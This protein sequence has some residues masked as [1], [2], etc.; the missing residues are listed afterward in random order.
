VGSASGGGKS[1]QFAPLDRLAMAAAAESCVGSVPYEDYGSGGTNFNKSGSSGPKALKQMKLPFARG[2]QPLEGCK[3]S[4]QASRR[5]IGDGDDGGSGASDGHLGQN[6]RQGSS[7]RSKRSNTKSAS[8]IRSC[9]NRHNSKYQKQRLAKQV[10]VLAPEPKTFPAAREPSQPSQKRGLNES[11][12]NQADLLIPTPA[13]DTVCRICSLSS[14]AVWCCVNCGSRACC[15]C[16]EC[17]CMEEATN[18]AFEY[19]S[20]PSLPSSVPVGHGSDF[21]CQLCNIK[22]ALA[23]AKLFKFKPTGPCNN[24]REDSKSIVLCVTCGKRMCESCSAATP[25]ELRQVGKNKS[26]GNLKLPGQDSCKQ[27]RN[28]QC[29]SCY[30]RCPS[31][32]ASAAHI[33]MNQDCGLGS[34]LGMHMDK[35][36]MSIIQSML[37]KNF[38]H[39]IIGREKYA[40]SRRLM[41]EK[42][43]REITG[44]PSEQWQTCKMP[45][46]KDLADRMSKAQAF[47]RCVALLMKGGMEEVAYEF[48]GPVSCLQIAYK[49]AQLPL[50]TAPLDLVYLMDG[51]YITWTSVQQAAAC[52]AHEVMAK[53]PLFE[54]RSQPL[55]PANEK[56]DPKYDAAEAGKQTVLNGEELMDSDSEEVF[57]VGFYSHDLGRRSAT[58]DLSADSILSLSKIRSKKGTEN[59]RVFVYTIACTPDSSSLGFVKHFKDLGR[60][61]GF[62]LTDGPKKIHARM[63]QDN[64]DLLWHMPGFNHGQQY[65]VL[66]GRPATAVVQWLGCAGPTCAVQGARSL[67]HYNLVSQDLWRPT[68]ESER[69]LLADCIYPLPSQP[70]DKMPRMDIHKSRYFRLPEGRPRLCFAGF[71]TRLREE[72]IIRTL[73]ILAECGHG[74][75]SPVLCIMLT[76]SEDM[77]TS[78]LCWAAKWRK[79]FCPEFDMERIL[80][81]RFIIETEEYHSF[82]AQMHLFLD[83]FPCGL[84]TSLLEPIALCKIVLVWC[85]PD[86]EWPSLV[87]CS[88][89]KFGGYE[90]LV[91]QSE[92][93]LICSAVRFL[94][95]VSEISAMEQ[96]LL[97]DKDAD[98]GIFKRDRI[99]SILCA[100]IPRVVHMVKLSH[101]D[102]TRLEGIDLTKRAKRGLPLQQMEIGVCPVTVQTP[103]A[104]CQRL[105][106]AMVATGRDFGDR[107]AEALKVLLYAQRCGIQL[108]SLAGS[109]AYSHALR[110]VYSKEDN[111][112][113][114]KGKLLILKMLH[115]GSERGSLKPSKRWCKIDDL[116]NDQNL[117]SVDF[118]DTVSRSLSSDGSPDR[119]YA[120]HS[121][122]VFSTKRGL[123]SAG[124][125]T[126]QEQNGP[127]KLALSFHC[128]EAMPNNLHSDDEYRKIVADF[129]DRGTISTARNHFE[130]GLFQLLAAFHS[131]NL[132]LFDISLG[133]LAMRNGLPCVIDVGSSQELKPGSQAGQGIAKCRTATMDKATIEVDNEGFVFLTSEEVHHIVNLKGN[134]RM[135]CFGTFGCRSEEM[136]EEVRKDPTVFSAKFAAHFDISSAAMVV[137]QGYVPFRRKE[138]ESWVFRLKEAAASTDKMYTF[139]CSGL[140]KGVKLQQADALR[141]RADMLVQFLGVPWREQPI[142]YDV[143]H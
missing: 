82:L 92:E 140:R 70:Y 31:I 9:S 114:P 142:A 48:S 42:M 116:S 103:R 60:Y 109:G 137:A 72:T 90:E 106:D 125:L 1:L 129:C 110:G 89:L 54:Q 32:V 38:D 81:Y 45:N 77:F 47:C 23:P 65:E 61:R 117:V 119:L 66:S 135:K 91:M 136:A 62:K 58:L 51:K 83:T 13:E 111:P 127:P 3:G 14:K 74:P 84:H 57:N 12:N 6:G 123:C 7:S 96:R 71:P 44:R 19:G 69:A 25:D 22:L 75:T 141:K 104:Q 17:K 133:N 94:T 131:K 73:H 88:V 37:R 87:A 121:V 86:A 112:C 68:I 128:C 43:W 124:Y 29:L 97:A 56:A 132:Y 63:Q 36:E 143:L 80:P 107:K 21:I 78:I 15:Q 98:S 52:Q 95:N 55:L 39:M 126:L 113:V 101:G 30:C 122:P 2:N 34:N 26:K 50:P 120:T 35:T 115:G 99:V 102:M 118:L 76:F 28:F 33:Q 67:I 49:K 85:R 20:D 24:C 8:T 53:L 4:I 130:R 41:L 64:L 105:Y 5:S 139:L 40:D 59:F 79:Q 16:I 46:K 134:R 108:Q 93:A 10:D 27:L 18:Q 11:R 138:A 100:A